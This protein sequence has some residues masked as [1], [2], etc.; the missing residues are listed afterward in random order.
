[1]N[2]KNFLTGCSFFFLSIILVNSFSCYYDYGLNTENA[3]VVVTL[4]DKNYNFNNVT[5]YYFV[6][7]VAHFGGQP[8]TRAY[9][10]L[11]KS[12]IISNL[13]NL[14]WTRVTDTSG[15][16]VIVVGV[17]VTTTD[18][19][20]VN[21]GYAWWDYWGY[22]WYYP[23]DAYIINGYSFTTGTVAILMTDLQKRSGTKLPLQW[24]GVIN[25]LYVDG[26]STSQ[27]ITSLVNQAFIQSPYLR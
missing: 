3:D 19:V 21:G 16:G 18:N 15:S 23:P 17:G 8:Y 24:T 7:S 6:D 26:G 9:D 14:G 27:R 10:D 20:V 5:K 22:D 13:N 2:R 1:M 25:G 12:T 4:Y 11:L